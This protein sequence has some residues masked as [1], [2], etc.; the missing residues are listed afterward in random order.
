MTWGEF[1]RAVEAQGLKDDDEVAFID[2][3]Q[4]VPARPRVVE[5]WPG[6]KAIEEDFGQ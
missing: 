1:K 6:A 3:S 2:F 5:P 4:D